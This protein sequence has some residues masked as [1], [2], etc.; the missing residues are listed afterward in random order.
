MSNPRVGLLDENLNFITSDNPLPTTQQLKVDKVLSTTSVDL[1]AGSFSTTITPSYDYIIDNISFSFTT[2]VSKT[3]T[4]TSDN[5]SQLYS[6][7]VSN[8]SVVIASI[9]YAQAAGEG[10]T[11]FVSSTASAC[12]MSVDASIKNS[13]VALQADPVIATG[14]NV[15][16]RVMVQDNYG[17]NT[18]AAVD[19]LTASLS[20]IDVSHGEIHAG[21]H[22]SVNGFID[23]ANASSSSFL[24]VAPASGK[25]AHLT[26]NTMFE[27]EGQID[28]YYN[29][30]TS[31]LGTSVAIINRNLGSTTLPLST[32]YSAPG[33]TN[34]GTLIASHRVGSGKS[35]P[36]T[37]RVDNEYIIPS[38]G[39]LYIV[40]TNH[41]SGTANL[42]NYQANW[43]EVNNFP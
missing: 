13:P 38:G 9:N 4:I 28:V 41:A 5:G 3:I 27:L 31:S 7:T 15:I 17:H 42:F 32:I 40:I 33:V 23:I 1:N 30:T 26:F 20:I 35:E 25:Q 2:S 12:E 24:F 10:F 8:S 11:I 22:F 43:Y 37:L 6:S 39:S 21:R 14:D 29:P 18:V 36:G 34:S 16:G 19:P